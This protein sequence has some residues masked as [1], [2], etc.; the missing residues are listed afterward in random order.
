MSPAS[1]PWITQRSS[2]QRIGDGMTLPVWDPPQHLLTAGPFWDAVAEERC[3]LPRCSSCG[4]WQ[5]Y[6]ET[7]GP[8]CPEGELEWV[9]LAGTGFVYSY[10]IVRRS[11]LPGQAERAPYT[12]VLVELDGASGPRLV[13]NFTEGEVPEIGQRVRLTT[14]FV[15][16][17]PR[18]IF[19]PTEE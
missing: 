14:Q 4:A 7:T 19:T 11:F 12:I 13:A 8:D 15:D 5:W 3:V 10:T 18:P 9:E 1:G 2:S 17:R 16:G 6:P